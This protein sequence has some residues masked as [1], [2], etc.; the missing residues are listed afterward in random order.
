MFDG[1]DCVR[2]QLGAIE[3][4]LNGYALG[5]DAVIQLLDFLMDAI[6]HRVGVVALLEEDDPFD[7]VGIVDDLVVVIDGLALL[8]SGRLAGAADLAE[9]DLRSLRNGGD[10]LDGDGRAVGGFDDGV[11]NILHAGVETQRLHIDL[12]RTL[13]NK[14][15]AAVGVV[16]G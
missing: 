13:L 2:D 15:S 16:V 14:A 8:H 3:K 6:E 4:R 12:L 10:V 1:L 11:L 5:Q 7:C 9:A